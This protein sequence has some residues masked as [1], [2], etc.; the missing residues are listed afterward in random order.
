MRRISLVSI[1]PKAFASVTPKALANSSPGFERSE[2][3]GISKTKV[4]KNAESV[5]QASNPFRVDRD[6]D[7]L[8]QGC[9]FAPTLG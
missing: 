3:P 5:R 7:A 8:T 9:R 1:R 6:I 2:N 4:V